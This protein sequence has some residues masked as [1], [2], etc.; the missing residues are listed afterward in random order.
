MYGN[1]HF[2]FYDFFMFSLE[3]VAKRPADVGPVLLSDKQQRVLV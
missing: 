3:E 2:F 1:N